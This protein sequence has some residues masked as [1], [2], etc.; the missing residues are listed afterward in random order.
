MKKIILFLWLFSLQHIF[1]L[2]FKILEETYYFQNNKI[3]ASDIFKDIEN[4]FLILEIPKSSNGYQIKSTQLIDKFE[5]EGM[6]VGAKSALVTFKKAINANTEGI[7]NHILGLFLQE[8]AKNGIAIN[9]LTIEQMTPIDFNEE[10]IKEIDF[11]KKLLKRKEGSFDVVVFNEGRNRKIFFRYTIDATLNVL[12][13]N[14]PL[15]GGEPLNYSNTKIEKIPF[16]KIGVA[17]MEQSDLGRVALRS[18]TP[19]D[20]LLTKD[21]LIAKRV[22]KKGDKIVISVKENGVLLE[23]VLEAQKNAAIGDVIKAKALQGKKTYEVEII[24]KGRGKLL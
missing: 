2:D 18:Y 7:K 15:S 20:T 3:Y 13:T 23:F 17:L 9:D 8:Y 11:N 22:V 14:T 16:D 12:K 4:D 5:Q 21:R 10:D 24:G 19:S 6:H 1:A